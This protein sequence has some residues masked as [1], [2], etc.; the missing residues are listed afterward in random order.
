MK[1]M[2][3]IVMTLAGLLLIA[4][5]VLKCHQMIDTC[6]PSWD[7]KAAAAITEAQK[8]GEQMP[9]WKANVLGF[10]ESYEF[11]LFQIPLEF[12]LG[13]WLVK[14]AWI[15]GTLG[16]LFFIGVTATKW[17]TGAAD[18]G[19]WGTISVEPWITLFCIDVPV[20][21][22]MV[23]FRPKGTKLLPP[24]WPNLFYLL[25]VF[26]P[27]IGLMVAAPSAL[28]TL[29]PDC[30]T[31]D[32]K[33]DESAQL[34][35]QM[36]KLKQDLSGKD[37]EIAGL[38]KAITELKQA[39]RSTDKKAFI[40]V[41]EIIAA[42]KPNQYEIHIG[43][44][45]T[46]AL[47][48]DNLEQIYLSVRDAE[49]QTITITETGQAEITWTEPETID[50]TPP[51]NDTSDT[52][53]VVEQWDWLEFVVEDDVREQISEGLVVVMMHRFNCEVCEEMA[54]RYSE[55]YQQLVDQNIAE[56]KI[57]FLAVPP[58]GDE[59]HIPED[60]A[61]INGNLTDEKDWL[62]M[63][64]LVVALLDGE[65]MKTWEQGTAPAPENLL[66]EVFG[67]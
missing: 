67:E 58:Y 30:I 7:A 62:V 63:S 14:A 59:D 16:F 9:Q 27:T 42:D 18:C 36:H 45:Q 13:V 41:L 31:V 44:K 56:F 12:A 54:P 26:V 32:D 21:L 61:C 20:F 38:Q 6:I 10:W 15:A 3:K 11:L 60:T 51:V 33:P 17:I 53:P 52:P 48:A 55:Y 46:L 4:A 23:I 49:N 37:K 35:L 66:E 57:A 50:V 47:N 65:L 5:T 24:P 39:P 25:C 22:A 1:T 19:C 8:A 64:P 28:V 29:R 34:K 2:N 43:G 40:G